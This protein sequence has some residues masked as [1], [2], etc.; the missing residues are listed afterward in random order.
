MIN[1]HPLTIK[2]YVTVGGQKPFIEWLE[3][4]DKETRYRIKERLD[5]VSLGNLGDC[6]PITNGIFELRLNFGPGYRV[7]FGQES[8]SIILLLYGGN[9]TSQQKDI[10]KARQ[11]WKDYLMR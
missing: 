11:Y 10:K 6:K 7:Y 3:S 9:K 1:V 5:R 8:N 2:I 4:L